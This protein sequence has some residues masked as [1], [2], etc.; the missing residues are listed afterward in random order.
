MAKGTSAL[1]RM[2]K[3]KGRGGDSVLAHLTPGEIVIPRPLAENKDFKGFLE[4]AFDDSGASL[5]TFT[6]GSGE[7]RVNPKTN[8]VEFYSLKDVHEFSTS[9]SKQ[10]KAA[11]KITKRYDPASQAVRKLFPKPEPFPGFEEGI[12]QPMPMTSRDDDDRQGRRR[13][14]RKASAMTR[15]YGELT[16]SKPGVL[17]V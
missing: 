10:L 5:D 11:K 14:R 6:V 8:I 4:A 16:L 1:T 17:G 12:P 2:L 9:F 13:K 3:K 15:D 7:N